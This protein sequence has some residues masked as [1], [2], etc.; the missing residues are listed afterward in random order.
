M[1]HTTTIELEIK[2]VDALRQACKTLGYEYQ[3][4][5]TV[6][7]YDGTR[8]ENCFSIKIPGW[9]YPVVC[10]DG[11]VHYDNYQGAWGKQA[12]LDRLRQRY[13]TNAQI[14]VAKKKGY[15]VREESVDG[16]IKLILER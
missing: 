15:R 16:K 12:D 13:A 1:S 4:N 2:D 10:K 9:H 14:A 6:D 8:V 5:V 3:E 11:R 7:L